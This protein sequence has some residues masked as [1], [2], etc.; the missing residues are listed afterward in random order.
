M[1]PNRVIE[2]SFIA[3][4][5]LALALLW[6]AC[7]GMGQA[8]PAAAT[9]QPGQVIDFLTH[10]ISWYHQRAVEQQVATGPADLT[11]VQE[12]RL[13]ADQIVQLAFEY[14]RQQALL[15]SRQANQGQAQGQTPDLGPYQQMAHAGEQTD[16]ELQDTEDE[17]RSTQSKLATAG[18]AK[19]SILASTVSEFRR[20][21]RK[22]LQTASSNCFAIG[23]F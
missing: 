12:N 10:T 13:T 3:R 1:E 6:S 2:R 19:R 5:T 16:K 14:A 23:R 4:L 8:A 20:A 7:S 15:L 11:F 17:L 18:P 21:T 22:A 9:V